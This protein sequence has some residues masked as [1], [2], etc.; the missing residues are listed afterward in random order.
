MRRMIGQ[1]HLPKSLQLST[2]IVEYQNLNVVPIEPFQEC[3]FI[4]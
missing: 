3:L 1:N 4:M 2:D